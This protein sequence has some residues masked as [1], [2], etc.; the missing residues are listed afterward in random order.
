MLSVIWHVLHLLKRSCWRLK[1]QNWEN[2]VSSDDLFFSRL[3]KSI[4]LKQISSLTIRLHSWIG[5]WHVVFPS[6]CPKRIFTTTNMI[7]IK[8]Y[9]WSNFFFTGSFICDLGPCRSDI[10]GVHGSMRSGIDDSRNITL[11]RIFSDKWIETYLV[12]ATTQ[13]CDVIQT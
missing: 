11:G 9:I 12:V 1:H 7:P 3:P 5:A 6:N 10:W 13:G 4:I 8:I 2:M